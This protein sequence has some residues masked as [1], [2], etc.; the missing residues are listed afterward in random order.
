MKRGAKPL[1][2]RAMTA[3]ERQA[4][5]RATHADGTPTLRYRRPADQ[6]S[7][8][9]RWRDAVAELLALQ[10]DYRIW[11]GSLPENLK[12]SATA[13]MLRTICNLDLADLE[14]TVPPRGFGRDRRPVDDGD[15][16]AQA[17]DG[18]SHHERRTEITRALR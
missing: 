13:D 5:F 18:G 7:R 11:L 1:G 10:D 3:A 8:A 12:A 9:Q 4:R 17:G 15:D 2:E 14:N 6:R 16:P